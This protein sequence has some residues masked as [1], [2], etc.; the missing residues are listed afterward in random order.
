MSCFKKDGTLK[1]IYADLVP[2]IKTAKPHHT[3]ATVGRSDIIIKEYDC[4]RF[5]IPKDKYKYLEKLF[6]E[7]NAKYDVWYDLSKMVTID[8]RNY[9]EVLSIVR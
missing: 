6:T 3:I 2:Y 4:Y 9:D 1:K 5:D 8:V 7:L